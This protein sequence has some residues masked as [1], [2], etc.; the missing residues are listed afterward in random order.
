MKNLKYNQNGVALVICL[1]LLTVSTLLGLASVNST[2]LEEKMAGNIRSKHLSFQSTEAAL[3]DAEEYMDTSVGLSSIFDGT[4]G[5]Y[6]HSQP[7]DSDFPIWEGDNV[8]SSSWRNASTVNI[9]GTITTPQFIIEDLGQ[10]TIPGCL[11][12]PGK[13]LNCT[14]NYYRI[15]ARGVG[16]S[17]N[18]TLIQATYSKR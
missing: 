14:L 9:N 13:P 18:P 3:R 2:I 1:I 10:T 8:A 11:P 12:E 7:G 4:N 6:P 5:Q 17:N 16:L 15:T